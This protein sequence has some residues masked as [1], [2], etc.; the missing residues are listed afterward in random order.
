M[1][2]LFSGAFYPMKTGARNFALKFYKSTAWKN[3]SV[4]YRK[5]H[6]LCERCLKKGLYVRSTLVHHKIHI[7]MN[8]YRDPKILL[9]D[10][11][12]EALCTD[13]HAEEHSTKEHIQFNADGSLVL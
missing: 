9:D 10:S 6:P 12:L 3:K 11:N 13:C 2:A 5:A 8:N 4:A 1:A 7:N